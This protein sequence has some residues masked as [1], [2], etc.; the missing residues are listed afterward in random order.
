[1]HYTFLAK[2]PRDDPFRDL[3]MVMARLSP[4]FG[5]FFIVNEASFLKPEDNCLRYI[6]FNAT[7]F[8]VSEKLALT[9]RTSN[10]SIKGN[11][12]CYFVRV[13]AFAS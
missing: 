3:L 9:F 7:G 10:Q 12:V 1:L 11:G 6:I 2:L 13:G 4:S 5:K 8:K